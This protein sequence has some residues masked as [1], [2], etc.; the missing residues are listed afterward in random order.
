[1]FVFIL[2]ISL[3]LISLSEVQCAPKK[4]SYSELKSCDI[5]ALA[6][7]IASYDTVVNDIIDYVVSGPFKGKTFDE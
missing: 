1:M 5:G 6:N 2:N 3:L 4:K 7:E